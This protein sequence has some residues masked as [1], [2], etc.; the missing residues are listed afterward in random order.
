MDLSAYL[1][2]VGFG[3]A[4]RPDLATLTA[5]MR[6]H[7]LAV[8]F[9]NV[10]VQLGR[11]LDTS[12]ARAFDKIVTRRRGGWC[13]EMNGVLGWALGEIGFDVTRIAAG[14]MR[15]Q[16]GDA[17]M[18]N[19]L[20]LIVVLDGRR[21]LVDGGFG[22]ALWAPLPLELG[23]RWDEPFAVSLRAEADGYWRFVETLQGGPFSF[24]FR[25]A[26]ADEALLAAKCDWQQSH[27][28]SPFVQNLV[29]Q[30]RESD[31]VHV[32][33]RGRVFTRN[34]AERADKRVIETR[35]EW[36]ALM[37]DVFGIDEAEMAG[38]WPAICQR[39]EALFPNGL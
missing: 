2:R 13:Y 10:D 36:L 38:L 1:D 4:A 14:V 12:V 18:G 25:D 34:D 11:P 37:R 21:Y 32:T 15:E 23:E 29:A 16:M 8:P 22:S 35:D 20:A 30:K 24:D 3:G 6:A 27:E 28:S 5:V 33:M 31:R 39:H 26:L 7:V 9:E 19:H 17:Q